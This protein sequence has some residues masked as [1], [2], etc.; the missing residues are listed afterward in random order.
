MRA[1]YIF[2]I[3]VFLYATF[4]AL[5]LGAQDKNAQTKK[6][7]I[8]FILADDLGWA[9]VGFN[10][11]NTF[12]ETP[13]IDSLANSGVVF[14]N[15]YASS[16]VC[17]P[18]RYS[19]ETGKYPVRSGITNFLV[20][21]REGKFAPAELTENMGEER[22][23]A[24]MMKL[25]GYNT[26]FAG[27]YHLGTK[28][29][30]MPQNRGYDINFGGCGY[31]MPRGKNFY[32]S[33]YNNPALKD[34]PKGEYL[35]YRLTD[36]ICKYISSLDASK[37]VFIMA[38]YY[39]VH[40]PLMSKKALVEKYR[41][42]RDAINRN[43][44]EEFRRERQVWPVASAR[45]DKLVQDSPEYAAMMEAL[46]TCVGRLLDSLKKSGLYDDTIIIF[47]SD[48]G[49]LSTG[50]AFSTS[51]APLRCGKGWLYE[52]G[53]RV[54]TVI[55]VP[56]K[57]I[58]GKSGRANFKCNIPISNVDFYATLCDFAGVS[59]GKTDGISLK[60]ALS[61]GSLP[62]RAIFWHYPHYSNQGGFPG[63]AIR[64]GDWKLLEDFEDGRVELYNIS[65]DLSE[66][67]DL[68]NENPQIRDDLRKKLHS[69]Y[70]ETGAKFL[71]PKSAGQKPWR[72]DESN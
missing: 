6:P 63:G 51:N 55:S 11:P 23:I 57:F 42:K 56:N 36:E 5:P 1:C 22:T 34:G 10:N 54:P 41:K 65:K 30:C 4:F 62:K 39:L 61:G 32:F 49:G 14:T 52:G 33:P 24:Q 38:A 7:N 58:N 47:A 37:P 25:A 68:S 48:N 21:K 31:G 19:V 71:K 29:E 60:A 44:L 67:K 16:P 45:V 59:A 72:P 18:S 28:P 8:L 46:D 12:Y 15:A 13:N 26:F 70:A 50:E 35:P 40:T 9:D 66:T 17:S 2:C 27:K 20:G 64:L 53:I 69:W 3:S 43:G